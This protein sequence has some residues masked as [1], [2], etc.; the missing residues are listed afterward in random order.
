MS[1]QPDGISDTE[2]MSD[3][4]KTNVVE[5]K[6]YKA[7]EA[8]AKL[9]ISKSTFE[10]LVRNKLIPKRIFYGQSQGRYP[11]DFIDTLASHLQGK[12]SYGDVA[13]IVVQVIGHRP[14]RAGDTDWIQPGDLPYVLALD[15]EMYGLD[16]VIDMTITSKWWAKNP[17]QC[18]ILFDKSDRTRIWGVLTVMPLPLP[19]IYR[20]L[21]HEISERE[22]TPDDIQ[23]YEPDHTYYGY[24][25][26]AIIRPEHR[27]H[28]R[29]LVQSYLSFLCEQYP[30]I[31]LERIFGYASTDE[32]F[33]LMRQLLFSPRYDLGDD[34]FELDLMRRTHSRLIRSFQECVK[35]KDALVTEKQVN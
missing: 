28:F 7:S 20:L 5:N 6:D 12:A 13:L 22:I 23:L 8:I 15:Y 1:H 11:R 19:L 3:E 31:R 16:D 29:M 27:A 21:N 30:S 18:R 2:V 24:V 33:D 10:R 35:Q 32:G 25:A 34:A 17:C 14:E 9:G 4:R 26:S